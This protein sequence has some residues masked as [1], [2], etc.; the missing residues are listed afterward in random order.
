[1]AERLFVVL[2]HIHKTPSLA[3]CECCHIKFFTP[4]E[5]MREP[6]EADHYLRD[7]FASHTCR[8]SLFAS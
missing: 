1:M 5:L 8:P 4:L 3:T 7:K 6:L 2:R